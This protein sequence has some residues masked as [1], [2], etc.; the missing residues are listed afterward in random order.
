MGRDTSLVH[1]GWFGQ[2]GLTRI[3]FALSWYIFC[4]T[5]GIIENGGKVSSDIFPQSII[6]V[7][8]AIEQESSL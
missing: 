6:K 1:Q 2:S 5:S 8:T 4:R 7:F 3:P